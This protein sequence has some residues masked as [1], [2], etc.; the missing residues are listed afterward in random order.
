MSEDSNYSIDFLIKT[1]F[2]YELT[3]YLKQIKIDQEEKD[4]QRVISYLE[5]RVKEIRERYK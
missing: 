2:E 5:K 3:N 1:A 4:I